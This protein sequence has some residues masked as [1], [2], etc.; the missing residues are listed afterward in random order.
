MN[1]DLPLISRAQQH[2]NAVAFQSESGESSYNELLN[3]SVAW[4]EE[5]LCERDD[6]NESRVAYLLPAGFEYTVIQWAIWRAGGI[7]VP[8]S[9]SATEP[10]LEY[11]LRDSQANCVVVTCEF[12]E[13]IEPLCQQLEL[14]CLI[15]DDLPVEKRTAKTLPIIDPK[16][17][18]LILYT[19]GTTSKPKGV[20]TTHANIEAQIQSLIYAW[21]WKKTD[22]IPLFLPLHHIHGIINVMSCALWAGAIIEPFPWFEM[23]DILNRVAEKKYTLFMAVPTIYVKLIQALKALPETEGSP[24]I[25]GFASM[26]L[27]VSGSAALPASV[28]K[29]W[30]EL[31]SQKLLERYG[32]TEI[33]MGLSNPYLGER[34]PGTVGQ[35]LPGVQ[36]RLK[37]EQGNVI[38]EEGEAGEIQI[39][40]PALFCEY[41]S[42][43]ETTEESFDEGWFRTGDIA[44][45]EDGYYRI[46]GRH[47]VDIIKSGG[48]KISALEIEAALL[49]H[50][51]I[52]E[53]AVVGIPDETWGEAV[54][55]AVVLQPETEL[56]LESLRTW[57][58]DRLSKYKIPSRLLP[59]EKL[60]RNAMGKVGKPKVL[61]LF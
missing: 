42:R 23:N 11:T 7:A 53:C 20:V 40:G 9:L 54:A 59:I 57:C 3:H 47:S 48:Y 52:A 31:T 29:E 21:Q 25:T 41:W 49:D 34:R 43:P 6:L 16:R 24:I 28:H 33:G 8:L 17:K 4:A 44:V 10:E 14:R 58:R 27:M 50:P 22:R 61:E 56:N 39:Q 2:A 45:C 60:P 36:L 38:T 55:A 19:S 1:D 37:S 46:M 35:P 5:L 18:A 13:K 15:V 51:A 32:M 12:A 26:R 30:T